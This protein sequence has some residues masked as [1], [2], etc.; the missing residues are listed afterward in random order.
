MSLK[1]YGLEGERL[2]RAVYL[3]AMEDYQLGDDQACLNY[4]MRYP[5]VEF[6][7]VD[8][9]ELCEIVD[10]IRKG[11]GYRP[12]LEEG[13]D[14]SAWY[15]MYLGL[16]GYTSS[17]LDT[18]ILAVVANS[19]SEDKIAKTMSSRIIST[20]RRKSS[21]PFSNCWTGSAGNTTGNPAPIC[22]RKHGR[23]WRRIHEQN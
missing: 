2:R 19:D 12:V 4:P 5:T 7:L 14:T 3:D 18:S 9:I 15:S 22:W 21:V 13:G 1:D 20:C 23:R 10:T 16:N 11:K 8:T 17:G 6:E